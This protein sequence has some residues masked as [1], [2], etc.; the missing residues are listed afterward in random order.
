MEEGAENSE[1]LAFLQIFL[2]IYFWM[3]EGA[4]NRETFVD[5]FPD[6]GG[7]RK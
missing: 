4:E 7:G 6:G 5:F 3:E 1:T 2:W